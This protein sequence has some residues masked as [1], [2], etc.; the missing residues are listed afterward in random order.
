MDELKRCLSCGGDATLERDIWYHGSKTLPLVTFV[1]KCKDCGI[2][3]HEYAH[4]QDAVD[5]W[6]LEM[7]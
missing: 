7:K 3:T 2:E 5:E 6:N 1:V 4:A